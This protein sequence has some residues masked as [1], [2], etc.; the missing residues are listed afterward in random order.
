MI[1]NPERLR[2]IAT[3]RRTGLGFA[4]IGKQLGL[5]KNTVIGLVARNRLD[6]NRLVAGS[7]GNSAMSGAPPDFEAL[8]EPL[9]PAAHARL[10]AMHATLDAVLAANRLGPQHRRKDD[11]PWAKELKL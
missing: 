8:L 7:Q 4:A 6:F 1:T 5:S 10:D 11:E 2:Q 9:T 3:L